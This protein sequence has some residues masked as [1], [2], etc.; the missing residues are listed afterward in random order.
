MARVKTW[1]D[2]RKRDKRLRKNILYSLIGFA[3][4]Y[5]LFCVAISLFSVDDQQAKF[6]QSLWGGPIGL[7]IQWFVFGDR[8]KALRA[9][10]NLTWLIAFITSRLTLVKFAFWLINLA[11]Y[12]ILLHQAGL[13]AQEANVVPAPFV[14][15]L[16]YAVMARWVITDQSEGQEDRNGV[17]QP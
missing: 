12:S 10:V 2:E 6:Y 4:S 13:P 14:S 7:A 11:A 3:I 1:F 17:I 5:T 15:M 8:V 9:K 16:F